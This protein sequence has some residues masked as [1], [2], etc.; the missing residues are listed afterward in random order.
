MKYFLPAFALLW[1]AAIYTTQFGAQSYTVAVFSFADNNRT[2]V[3]TQVEPQAA[4]L[5]LRAGTHIDLTRMSAADRL[6]LRYSR[7]GTL[8]RIPVETAQGLHII[9][10]PAMRERNLGPT[11]QRVFDAVTMTFSLLLAAFLG[12]RKPGIMIAALILYLG[13][14]A[15]SWPSFAAGFSALPDPLY[16]G[17]CTLLAALCD[18]FPVLVLAAFAVRFPGG[19]PVPRHRTAIRIVDS[20]VIVGF[21]A[22]LSDELFM[23][24]TAYVLLTALS[25]IVVIAACFV[26]LRYAKPS[27]RARVGIV[28]AS[29]IIGGVGYA[30]NMIWLRQYG[31]N[32]VVFLLYGG[33]SVIVVPLAVTYAIVRDRVFDVAFVLNRT[34]VYAITSTVVLLALAAMEF[35]AEQYLTALT[36]V[37]GIAVEFGIALVV[38]VSAR[39]VH[40]R[41]D[42]L[43]DNVLFRDRHQQESALR[44]FATTLQ[45]YTEQA[46]LLRDTVDVLVRSGRVHGAAIYLPDEKRIES[47]ASS[48]PLPAPAIDEND[49]AY[50]ELRA[51]RAQLQIHGVST[52][53]LGDRLYPMFLAGRLVGVISTGER[54]S[55]EEM[56]PDIDDAIARV[57]AA[58]A[59]SLAAI[60]T[61]RVR[62]ENALLHAKL[63]GAAI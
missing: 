38:I 37:E 2:A 30:A 25:A 42:R 50:V 11:A 54:E 46:P 3:V 6:R 52:G 34:L 16:I 5:G 21:I 31:G 22:A 56:P 35:A 32:F 39:I 13:G 23:T 24:R 28:F 18:W 8:L 49:P 9:V 44:R 33:L 48:Y 62:A 7:Q 14:G 51:H 63:A 47:A 15:L 27:D 60:E 1:L 55:G 53:F 29:V 19:D 43:V 26:A 58:L 17:V 45:F 12:F 20:L 40:G 10:V 36:R 61:D 59:V 41:V 57:A 4:R